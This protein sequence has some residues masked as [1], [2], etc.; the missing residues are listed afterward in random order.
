[1]QPS[2][3]Q[4]RILNAALTMNCFTRPVPLAKIG[5]A[6]LRSRWCKGRR[7]SDSQAVYVA[8]DFYSSLRECAEKVNRFSLPVFDATSACK[9]W[10]DCAT[11]RPTFRQQLQG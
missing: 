4:K 9:T 2:S 11:T 3:L 7:K 10:R 8:I 5:L 6:S 1:M